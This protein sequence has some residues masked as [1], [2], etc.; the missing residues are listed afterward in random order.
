MEPLSSTRGTYFSGTGRRFGDG[1]EE[2]PRRPSRARWKTAIASAATAT[3][4]ATTSSVGSV[5]TVF[6]ARTVHV[7]PVRKYS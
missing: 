1:R 7:A 2:D 4:I 5:K 3:P 6:G